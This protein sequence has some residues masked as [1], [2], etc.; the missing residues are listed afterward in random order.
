MHFVMFDIEHFKIKI[1]LAHRHDGEK[2]VKYEFRTEVQQ[3]QG[4]NF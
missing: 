1:L 2:E 4:K 3:R